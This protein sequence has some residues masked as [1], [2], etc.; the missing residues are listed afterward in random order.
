MYTLRY[1]YGKLG[2]FCSL[3]GLICLDTAS[4]WLSLLDEMFLCLMFDVKYPMDELCSYNVN[5]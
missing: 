3:L 5:C 4:S 1:R 2:K